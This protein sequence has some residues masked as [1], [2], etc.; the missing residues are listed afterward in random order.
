MTVPPLQATGRRADLSA[1][2]DSTVDHRYYDFSSRLRVLDDGDWLARFEATTRAW[3]AE[4]NNELS[5][6]LPAVRLTEA[7]EA[8]LDRL[9]FASGTA[10]RLTLVE[11]GDQGEWRTEALA[12]STHRGGGWISVTVHNSQN[13]FANRPRLVPRLLEHTEVRDGASELVDDTWIIG[14]PHLKEFLDVLGDPSRDA[15]VF[16]TAAKPGADLARVQEWMA[17]R[18]RELA[19]LAHS[20][21]LDA[22]SNA[23]LMRGLGRAMG[24]TPGTIRSFAP[25]PV[26]HDR[27]D[28][29]RHRVIGRGRLESLHP[30]EAAALVGR[31]ARFESATRPEPAVLRDARRAFD[32]KALDDRFR[33]RARPQ[34]APERAESTGVLAPERPEEPTA[35]APSRPGPAPAT[36]PVED[37]RTRTPAPAPLPSP[38]TPEPPPEESRQPATEELP[39]PAPEPTGPEP[40]AQ[41]PRSPAPATHDLPVPFEEPVGHSPDS[42]PE[43]PTPPAPVDE[44]SS[45]AAPQL[46][47][48]QLFR[49]TGVSNLADVIDHVRT[50]DQLVDEAAVEAQNALEERDRHV[51][52]A[53]ELTRTVGDLERELST[54]L[55]RRQSAE[56]NVR[57]LSLYRAPEGDAARTDVHVADLEVPDQFS[58]IPIAVLGLEKYVEFTGNGAVTEELDEFDTVNL[59]AKH[60][61]DGLLA[62][63]DYARACSTGDHDGS[64]FT[65]L[66]TTPAMHQGFAVSKFAAVESEST[67]SRR[68]LAEQRRFP[69][70]TSVDPSGAMVMWPHLKLGKIGRISPRLHFHDDVSGSGKV[71]VG[72]IGRHLGLAGDR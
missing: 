33:R 29:L 59:A 12:Y 61:W 38:L 31:I 68:D 43:A 30:R 41:E 19:G 42:A 63:H 39:A 34:H 15:P 10:Y 47:L 37:A 24:I 20:Y 8:K 57:A 62:L 23:S 67:M 13:R 52:A 40:A 5:P 18:S 22:E 36:T 46:L 32:R 54:E 48:D 64:L 60:C 50:M 2:E 4:K 27:T 16:V 49:L 6:G 66:Q 28:A 58:D 72:Y 53:T 65:Y 21:V 51:D 35:P 55:T 9:E 70:P 71:Y 3:L 44:P 45:P 14:R 26:P 1:V 69:V 17:R 7:A 11:Q 25:G 56:Q